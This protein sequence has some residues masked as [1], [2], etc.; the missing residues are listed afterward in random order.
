MQKFLKYICFFFKKKGFHI[1]GRVFIFCMKMAVYTHLYF[2]SEMFKM[3]KLGN[4]KT[5]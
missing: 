2:V 3:T 4:I 1:C 5:G